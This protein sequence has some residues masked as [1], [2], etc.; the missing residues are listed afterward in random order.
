MDLYDVAREVTDEVFGEGTYA[1]M[2]G[3]S[4]DPGVQA[5]IARAPKAPTEHNVEDAGSIG[6][7]AATSADRLR[8]S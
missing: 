2:N 1:E 5:A 6:Q 4:P 7:T 8:R 3:G